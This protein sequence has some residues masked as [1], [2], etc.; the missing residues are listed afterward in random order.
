[1]INKSFLSTISVLYVEDEELAREKLCKLLTKL[2]KRVDTAKNGKDGLEKFQESI[3]TNTTYDL[4][5]SDINM[6]IKNGIEMLADIRK[7]DAEI[8]FIYTTARS[9]SENLL[10]AI[11]LN[12]NHYILKPIDLQDLVLKAQTVCEKNYLKKELIE[13]Q[14]EMENFLGAINHVAGV[15]I[16]N[17]EGEITYVNDAFIEATGFSRDDIMGKKLDDIFHS[18]ISKSIIPTIW[19]KINANEILD[20][21]IRYNNVND[22][23]LYF[24]AAV[25]RLSGQENEYISIGFESTEDVVQKKDFNKK[26][27]RS[28]QEFNKKEATYKKTI[29]DYK[30]KLVQ[31]QNAVIKLQKDVQAEKERNIQKESQLSHYDSTVLS[32]STKKHDILEQK[33]KELQT[34]LKQNNILKTKNEE[35]EERTKDLEDQLRKKDA[36][37]ESYKERYAEKL[38]EIKKL[39]G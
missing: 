3:N 35:L 5:I 36:Q 1:M 32:T 15:Y 14:K 4:I 12:A 26:V 11:E 27:M 20:T 13:K 30:A 9:E 19:E 18:E 7:L 24:T 8:P 6:P 37:I 34:Y 10:K 22:E 31:F 25:F 29:E 17:D 39:K 21:V 2:F 23:P 38:A 28:F 16:F 33:Q